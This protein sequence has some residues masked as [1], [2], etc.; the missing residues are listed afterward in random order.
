MT[1]V[2]NLGVNRTKKNEGIMHLWLESEGKRGSVKITRCLYKTLCDIQN[3]D[4]QKEY[5]GAIAAVGKIGTY[6]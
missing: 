5:F 1:N 6:V 3:N 4:P 2:Y